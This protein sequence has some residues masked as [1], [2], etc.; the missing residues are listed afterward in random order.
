MATKQS[1]IPD[2]M[3]KGA[4]K[5]RDDLDGQEKKKK[6]R[7]RNANF[8]LFN[9]QR[10]KKKTNV[11]NAIDGI[12]YSSD[13]FDPDRRELIT[14]SG[15]TH[16]ITDFYVCAETFDKLNLEIDEKTKDL[17]D[18]RLGIGLDLEWSVNWSKGP[19]KTSVIQIC[20]DLEECYVVQVSKMSRIPASFV[21]F[22]NHPKTILHGVN[23]KNDLRKLERD[24][25]Y[26]KADPLIEKCLDL[27][28]FYNQVFNSSERWSLANLTLQTLK[29]RVDKSRHVRMSN[30]NM[31]LSEQ[32]LMYASLDVYV[33]KL[34][35]FILCLLPMKLDVIDLYYYNEYYLFRIQIDFTEN[36]QLHQRKTNGKLQRP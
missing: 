11:N 17:N 8:Q 6:D 16:Y 3:I 15:K 18:D 7:K 35:I 28:T 33:S 22:L 14:Y 26:I 13:K 34:T 32:Q 5:T 25:P 30:W 23:I 19:E 10:R 21:A 12:T 36:L 27:G 24:F 2:W 9:E 1:K 29:Q 20:C 31:P 4:K